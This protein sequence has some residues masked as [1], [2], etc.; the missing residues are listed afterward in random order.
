MV[1]TTI[2]MPIV[3]SLMVGGVDFGMAFSAHATVGKSV[4][5]AA[6]YLGSLPISD[7]GSLQLHLGD[8]EGKKFGGLW[9]VGP[10]RW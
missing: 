9:K 7:N 2:Y 10:R 4:R 8:C 5:D 6:R 1:E 3:I